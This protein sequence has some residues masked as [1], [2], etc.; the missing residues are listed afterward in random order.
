MQSNGNPGHDCPG[1]P[2]SKENSESEAI[3]MTQDHPD[4]WKGAIAG[5]AGGVLASLLMEQ[6]QSLWSKA[7][8]V[9]KETDQDKK[10]SEKDESGK[11]EDPATVKV[12]DAIS[13]GVFGESVPEQQKKLAGEAVHYAMG[14]TSGAIYGAAAELTPLV[15]VGAGLGFGT[16]VWLTADEMILPASGFSQPPQQVP[17]STH[18]YALVSHWVYG[19]VTELVR[20]AIRRAL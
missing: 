6:F 10:S 13:R 4:I 12:A 18:A 7:S 3:E 5:I 14:M 9:I 2:A 19:W 20:H 8:E 17:F 11:K 15:T 1:F 16:A